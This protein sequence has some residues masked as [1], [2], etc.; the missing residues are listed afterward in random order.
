MIRTNF[1]RALM[2]KPSFWK[3]KR[4]LSRV[5]AHLLAGPSFLL[6]FFAATP[7][8]D[9]ML[10]PFRQ[11][12]TGALPRGSRVAIYLIFPKAGVLPSHLRSIA[13]LVHSG[14]AP[15]IVSNCR[16]D[17]DD[18]QELCAVSWSVIERRNFGYDFGG[19]RDAI[20]FL[21]HQLA[22]LK[23]LVILNDSAWFPLPG[24]MD[25]LA[26]AEA[27]GVDYAAAT[28]SGAIKR[29]APKDFARIEW[30]PDKG[31]RN[32]HYASFALSLSQPVL[33]DPDFLR[34]WQEFR[35]SQDKNRTVRRGEIGLTKWVIKKGYSHAATTELDDLGDLLRT[36][37]D[38]AL[39]HLFR[40]II[41]LDDA[42]MTTLKRQLEA[43]FDGGRAD[44]RPLEKLILM[45]AARRGAGYALADYL[46]REKRFAF[47]KKS[48][49][50]LAEG[51]VG[52][53]TALAKE[54]GGPVGGEILAEIDLRSGK[55]TA[56]APPRP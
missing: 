22:E 49:T 12:T 5:F 7:Y 18:R 19:Y 39:I 15:L 3:V 51:G 36:M 48:P 26:E 54:F 16:L 31:R 1:V 20:L 27:L 23:R 10:A 46:V 53:I 9:R 42:E 34:F 21:D 43:E 47:L 41:V 35:L 45:I 25:W 37:P 29:P 2:S 32:F 14:Y 4:E 6:Q 13:Y 11:V 17:D 33:Q 44:R 40:G 30:H 55:Q 50:T 38:A 52:Q 56:G 28:W 24:G 8:H